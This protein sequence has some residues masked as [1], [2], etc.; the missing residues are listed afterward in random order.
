MRI[1]I[2]RGADADE[3]DNHSFGSGERITTTSDWLQAS[4]LLPSLR[5][6]L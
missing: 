6:S 4:D 5:G 1:V 3:I 2:R